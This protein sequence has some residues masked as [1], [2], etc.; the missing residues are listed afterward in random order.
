MCV[1]VGIRSGLSSV[2]RGDACLCSLPR[3]NRMHRLFRFAYSLFV[4]KKHHNTTRLPIHFV[5]ASRM[6]TITICI[7]PD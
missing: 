3:Y 7:L 1:M 2:M 5:L 6:V 4:V